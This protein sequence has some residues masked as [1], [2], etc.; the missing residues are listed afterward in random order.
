VCGERESVRGAKASVY[1]LD[2][3][4]VDWLE[5]HGLLVSRT[6]D[7]LMVTITFR[8]D[9]VPPS[10]N[11]SGARGHWRTFH[12]TKKAWQ[13][14][15]EVLLLADFGQPPRPFERC[16]VET[17]LMFP[18]KSGAATP[19][20]SVRCWRRPPETPSST[21]GGSLTTPLTATS[22]QTR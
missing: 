1:Q 4:G 16:R 21:A 9:D 19:A 10:L 20:T 14:T 5:E 8:Y 7:L 18:Q 6:A 15:I 2:K 17:K 3:A 12:K 22:S 11:Q 13:A